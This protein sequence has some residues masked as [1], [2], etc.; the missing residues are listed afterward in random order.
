MAAR[1][2]NQN[3]KV[4]F[5]QW[6]FLIII[7]LILAISIAFIILSIL[8]L[9][10]GAKIKEVAN[11]IP[12][13][14]QMVTTE[15]EAESERREDQLHS[16]ITTL[17]TDK[18][19]LEANLSAQELEL[20]Q[21]NQEIVRLNHLLEQTLADNDLQVE[22]ESGSG[23]KIVIDT[24]QE[25][26]AKSAAQILANMNNADAIRIL[27]DLDEDLRAAI[28]SALDPESAANFTEQLLNE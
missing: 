25:M 13:I 5:T 16:Q 17:K 19:E 14:N 12:V 27:R 3:K 8:D 4:R 11:Q 20:D 6:L 26:S 24:Y 2:G 15:E 18:A 21:L 23:L 10:P 22:Q 9:N 1:Q 28:L 7:P